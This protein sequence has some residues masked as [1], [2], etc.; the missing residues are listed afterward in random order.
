MSVSRSDRE[1]E[2]ARLA[3]ELA[4]ARQ[5]RRQVTIRDVARAAHVSVGTASKALNNS[6]SLRHETRERVSAAAR[7]LGFRPNTLAQSLHSGQTFTVG[8][9]SNDSFGRFTMPI[10]EGLEECLAESRVAVFMANATDDPDR[11]ARHVEQL[12][13]KRVDGMVVTARRADQRAPLNLRAQIPLIY[14]FSRVDDPEAYCLLPDDEGGARLAVEHLAG[15]GR[16]RIAHV[17]GPERFDAVRLRRAGYRAGLAASGLPEEEGFYLTGAWSESWGREAVDRLFRTRRGRPDAL[18]CGNDQIARGAADALRERGIDVPG[19]VALV[20]F[21]N[22][23]IM[24]AATR[25]PLTSIDMNLKTLGREAGLRLLDMI[26][27]KRLRGVNR[28]PCT[29]VV[30]E[31]SAL[32]A[33]GNAPKRKT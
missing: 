5:A 28:L 23:E 27:G 8:L 20:G 22:W 6:G 10:M 15:L 9:I 11:E 32:V 17:T 13:G 3:A 33:G 26:A 2:D 16:R 4:A 1:A 31:S 14:V 21:D 19:A 24:A 29:L 7:E 25:P 30:R 12:L 18:F